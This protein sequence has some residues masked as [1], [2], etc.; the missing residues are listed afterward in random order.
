M[1]IHD[2]RS[3]SKTEPDIAAPDAKREAAE[4]IEAAGGDMREDGT[5]RRV[6]PGARSAKQWNAQV[7]DLM[8]RGDYLDVRAS[9]E[10]S[11]RE[12]VWY[13]RVYRWLT[14]RPRVIDMNSALA[15]A[16]GR[17]LGDI[18]KAALEADAQNQIAKARARREGK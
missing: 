9:E 8:S 15:N 7:E 2:R 14:G 6:A 11:R 16:H 17:R 1:R 18:E 5:A 3:T 13:R 12:Q 10:F 4:A